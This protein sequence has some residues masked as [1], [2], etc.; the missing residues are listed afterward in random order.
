MGRRQ[1]FWFPSSHLAKVAEDRGQK[2]GLPLAIVESATAQDR[3]ESPKASSL[4]SKLAQDVVVK[5]R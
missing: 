2:K 1:R 3:S 5:G 4:Y